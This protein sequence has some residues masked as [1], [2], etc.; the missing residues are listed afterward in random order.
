LVPVKAQELFESLSALS[1]VKQ[2]RAN[3]ELS[4]SRV[5]AG[6]EVAQA[7]VAGEVEL[8]KL[9]RQRHGGGA[10]PL[11]VLVDDPDRDGVLRALGLLSP[12]D[13]VRVVD[14]DHLFKVLE[15]LPSLSTVRA[16]RRL[17]EELERL[18]RTGVASLNVRGL[19]TEYL[20]AIRLPGSARW[21]QLEGL[22]PERRGSW[23]ELLESLG[24]SIERLKQRG[25]LARVDGRPIVVVW[26]L[27]DPG[28]FARL[29]EQGRP[30]QG[31][32]LNECLRAG[33][34]GRVSEPL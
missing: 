26:P 27:A 20:Y 15:D 25:Y 12:E 5:V 34:R 24:Y 2:V 33:A 30:R 8:R 17:A 18:D 16:V 32:L 10:T 31:V 11:L 23:R 3:G 4:A 1:G 29:D 21:A 7:G 14:A 19:G 6:V 22:A 28:E 13:P 9:W